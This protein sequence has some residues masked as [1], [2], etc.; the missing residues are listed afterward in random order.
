M[1]LS[2]VT[3]FTLAAPKFA[4][5]AVAYVH[6][7]TKDDELAEEFRVFV[8]ESETEPDVHVFWIGQ[9]STVSF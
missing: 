9:P 1:M 3:I 7:K 6:P 4:G 2:P 5:G 8:S